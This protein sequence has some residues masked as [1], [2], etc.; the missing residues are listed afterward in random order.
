MGLSLAC[1]EGG[2]VGDV[3]EPRS[4]N[5]TGDARFRVENYRKPC[6]EHTHR[7]ADGWHWDINAE[8]SGG[9]RPVL[10]KGDLQHSYLWTQASVRLMEP[11]RGRLP[12]NVSISGTLDD[13]LHRLRAEAH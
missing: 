2:Q 8:Y 1:C 3:Y 10:L 13:F 9:R 7:H 5:L 4:A 11:A 6:V 12:R